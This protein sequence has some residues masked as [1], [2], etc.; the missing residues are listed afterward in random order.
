M[1]DLPSPSRSRTTSKDYEPYTVLDAADNEAVGGPISRS[2][3]EISVIGVRV[4]SEGKTGLAALRAMRREHPVLVHVLY[5][6][7]SVM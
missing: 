7:L 3:V 4:W 1:P 6:Y 2:S 5:T